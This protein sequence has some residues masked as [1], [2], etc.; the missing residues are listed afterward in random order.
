[1]LLHKLEEIMD[2]LLCSQD[3][4]SD[5]CWEIHSQEMKGGAS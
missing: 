2:E 1:M 4:E 5:R 3:G